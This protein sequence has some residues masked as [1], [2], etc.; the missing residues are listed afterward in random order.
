MEDFH[1]LP[2]QF[3][4]P[5]RCGVKV[6]EVHRSA[7]RRVTVVRTLGRTQTVCASVPV[8]ARR[9]TVVR[10][11][12]RA[13]VPVKARRVTVV[14][15]LG[16]ASVVSKVT[17]F[18]VSKVT[19]S[20]GFNGDGRTDRASLHGAIRLAVLQRTHDRASLHGAIRLA[21]LQRTHRPCVPTTVTRPALTQRTHSRYTS[22]R[23][24]TGCPLARH[25]PCVHT[26]DPSSH[27]LAGS[28]HTSVR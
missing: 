17:A 7:L 6:L 12:G 10:T 3:L 23:S 11:L 22:R 26:K 25:F 28:P 27:K 13:S 16:R 14:G 4:F 1:C 15:T 19:A 2:R 20:V 5:R 18:V 8:K 9:V 21:V 24:G